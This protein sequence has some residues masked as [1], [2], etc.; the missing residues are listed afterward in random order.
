MTMRRLVLCV[1]LLAVA[2]DVFA[3][4]RP[5]LR[6]RRRS[7]AQ[8]IVPAD[9]K[10]EGP[11]YTRSAPIKGGLTEGAAAAPD[12]TIYF[13]DIPFGSDKGMIV[14][15]DPKTNKSEVFTA[16][17]GKSN[18]LFVD[19]KGFLIACEGSDE[20]GRRV[21]K[22]DVKTKERTT[23]ADR[24]MGKRFNA[25]NDLTIDRQGRIYFTDPRYLGTEPRELE[26]RAVYRIETDGKVVEVTHDISKPNGIALSP[27]EKTLYV[28]DHDNGTDRIDPKAAKPAHGR[29]AL[30]AFPLGDDGL[31]S[32]PKRTLIDFGKEA[33]G[34]GMTVDDK[35]NLYLALRAENRPGVLITNPQGREIGFVPTGEPNQKIDADHPGK[36]FPSN[37]EFGIGDEKNVLYVTVDTSLYRVKLN[38]NGYHPQFEK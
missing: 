17:S 31:V 11:L 8:A 28:I 29:M 33:G 34:D 6:G 16:D 38:A 14:H 20:G 7:R 36:G 18:G 30:D 13:S 32:G 9:V 24:Y 3:Q 2:S 25:P 35:G 12:G 37:V 1:L 23:L 15:Y 22:W 19:A 21:S 5:R 10:L 26:H 27:D 4:I